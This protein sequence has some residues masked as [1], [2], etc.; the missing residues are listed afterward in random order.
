MSTLTDHD[1]RLAAT[2]TSLS[3]ER[4][5]ITQD[6]PHAPRRRTIP[7][8]SL[9]L[10]AATS[11]IIVI[12]RPRIFHPSGTPLS[13]IPALRSEPRATE[14]ALVEDTDERDNK[15]GV[16]K[17]QVGEI[18]GAGIVV[19]PRS[20][21]VFSKY[22]AR[23]T[24]VAVEP[25]DRVEAGQ[26]LIALDDAVAHIALEKAEAARAAADLT[27][28]ARDIDLLQA[29]A[30]LDRLESLA[31]RDAASRQQLEES[32]TAFARA[33]NALAQ[34]RQDLTTAALGVRSAEEPL[35]E[36]MVRA[37]FAGTVTR[38][39]AHVGDTVLA[40]AD[41]VRENQ[42]LLAI[43][44]TTSMAIDA[45]VAETNIAFLRPGL[46]GE[47]V[48]DGFPDRAFAVEVVRLAPIASVEK[49]TITVRLSLI[50]PPEGIRPNMAA[51]IRIP[52][53]D[54][55]AKNGDSKP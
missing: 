25:G 40:R 24:D 33:S 26:V 54:T 7:L 55:I 41:S 34:A 36:L 52:L 28:K 18:T 22:E 32:R 9:A 38:L 12:Y 44:D 20:T 31:S 21:T 8:L 48:L 43:T 10:V 51:R 27:V 1:Q 30:S 29:R 4:R 3:L 17:R 15:Q 39:S 11:L 47:A 23:I 42:S 6:P 50:D 53:P 35:A 5:H 2:L 45:D 46:R 13:S 19:A 37:P 14:T 16:I 49:G